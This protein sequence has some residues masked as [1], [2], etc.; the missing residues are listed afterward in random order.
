MPQ[1]VCSL[2]A[3]KINDFF[4]YR[5]M[6]SATNIQT[7]RLLGLP[8][9]NQKPALNKKRKK[10]KYFTDKLKFFLLI[11][12]S[13]YQFQVGFNDMEGESILGDIGNDVDDKTGITDLNKTKKKY[14]KKG[15][16]L[17]NAPTATMIPSTS[18]YCKDKNKVGRP[19]IQNKFN[20]LD[21][22]CI[23]E[24]DYIK[25][26][27]DDKTGILYGPSTSAA[28]IKPPPKKYYKKKGATV[29]VNELGVPLLTLKEPNKRERKREI[30]H[31]KKLETS[32]KNLNKYNIEE[33]IY[34]FDDC[35]LTFFRKRKNVVFEQPL[36]MPLKKP[37][38]EPILCNI[39]NQS[40]EGPTA[41]K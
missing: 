41:L 21:E 20:S 6:C 8:D 34:V 16:I 31:Q 4:E 1:T 7:R 32:E 15:Q 11:I 10:V 23:K 12:F 22:S 26:E 2:C 37:K 29:E 39:C 38:P 14:R 5:E 35:L 30:E 18:K 19:R 25:E 27:I 36:A 3:D 13:D 17:P 40:C 33:F 24:E 9:E 28:G